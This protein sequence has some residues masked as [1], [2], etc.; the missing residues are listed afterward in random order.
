M[1]NT[2]VVLEFTPENMDEIHSLMKEM[3]LVTRKDF[4]TCAMTIFKWAVEEIKEGREIVSINEDTNTYK[5]LVMPCL[6]NARAN[7]V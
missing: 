7:A 6:E 5:T 4:F 2:R 3:G 1:L